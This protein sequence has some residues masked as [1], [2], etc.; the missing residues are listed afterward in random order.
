MGEG[1]A[2]VLR[3]AARCVTLGRPPGFGLKKFNFRMTIKKII[4][5][6]R[7]KPLEWRYKILGVDGEKRIAF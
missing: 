5:A 1:V 4:K 6:E 3:A 2:R 7:V